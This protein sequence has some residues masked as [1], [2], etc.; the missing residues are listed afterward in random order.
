MSRKSL[1]LRDFFKTMAAAV[2]VMSGK[3]MVGATA[4]AL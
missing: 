1:R 4:P 2:F 3:W